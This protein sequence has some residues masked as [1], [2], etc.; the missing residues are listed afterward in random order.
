M[1]VL[2]NSSWNREEISELHEIRSRLAEILSGIWLAACE[3]SQHLNGIGKSSDRTL[4]I[5]KVL[6]ETPLGAAQIL[7]RLWRILKVTPRIL[8]ILWQILEVIRPGGNEK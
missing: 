1:S 4:S 7:Q 2:A 6:W 8:E 3:V 5:L